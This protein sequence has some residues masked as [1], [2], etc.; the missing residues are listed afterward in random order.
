MVYGNRTVNLNSDVPMEFEDLQCGLKARVSF[1]PE[2][3]KGWITS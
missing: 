2:R 1:G 3:K